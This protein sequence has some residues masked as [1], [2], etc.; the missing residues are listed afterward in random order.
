L[1][2]GVTTITLVVITALLSR[3]AFEIKSA[4]QWRGCDGH[5]RAVVSIAQK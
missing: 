3:K 2:F 5:M 1:P 4:I